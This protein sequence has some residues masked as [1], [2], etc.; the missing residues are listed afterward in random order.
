MAQFKIVVIGAGSFVFGP[1]LLQQAILEHRL[2]DIDMVLVDIDA[3]MLNLM[4]G[5]GRRMAHETGVHIHLSTA[6]DWKTALPGADFVVTAVAAQMYQRFAMDNEIIEKYISGHQNSEFGGIAGISY[7]LRQIELI[8]RITDD[9]KRLCPQAWLLDVANPLPRVCQAA[10]ENGIKTIGFCA[11]AEQIYSMVWQLFDGEPLPFPFSKGR[12][13][14]R[15]TTA[16]LNHYVW[17]IEAV[18]CKTSADL[19]PTIRQRLAEG[20]SYRNPHSEN[21]ARK[22][23]YLL[24]P[25]DD[26]TR[27]FFL[28]ETPV[29]PRHSPSH[30]SLEERLHR[31]NLLKDVAEGR[32]SW[33]SILEHPSW[34]HPIAFA[35]VL[36]AN[37]PT[38]FHGLNLINEGQITNLPRGV[39]VETPCMVDANGAH[40]VALTLPETVQPYCQHTAQVTDM[41]V[42]AAMQRSRKRLHE[43]VE[44]DPTIL[45]KAAGIRA[46]DACLEVH[47]DLIP[48]YA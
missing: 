15:L 9:M 48:A 13:K 24:A 44:A 2:N 39:Y 36:A 14:F 10:H 16:G 38:E 22:T 40:P 32:E 20:K 34:E 25:G 28:P 6:T 19:L 43:A 5:V 18:D 29:R 11:V 8:R 30:G 47:A 3:E 7:S 12:E 27:D 26:H 41:I 46:I 37:Q 23:G 42:R 33:D 21:M 4:A 35:A 17:L 45:D 1:S 31:V